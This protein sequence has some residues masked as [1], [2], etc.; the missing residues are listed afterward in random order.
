M[1]KL[2]LDSKATF[3]KNSVLSSELI[4]GNGGEAALLGEKAE[5]RHGFYG[6]LSIVLAELEFM[7]QR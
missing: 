5:G 6:P 3:K 2:I 4:L 7:Y 1:L